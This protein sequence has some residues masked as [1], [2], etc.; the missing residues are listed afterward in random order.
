MRNLSRG[1]CVEI[2]GMCYVVVYEVYIIWIVG[3]NVNVMRVFF[4]LDSC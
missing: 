4:V 2:R 1:G 3:K